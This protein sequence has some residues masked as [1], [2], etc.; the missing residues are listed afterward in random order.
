MLDSQLSMK[1]HI[2][3]ITATCFFQLRRLR[4]IRR[5]F[6]QEVTRRLVSACVTS[7]ND[8]SP[9]QSNAVYLWR[10]Y[11]TMRSELC[12]SSN[13]YFNHV[14]TT[15]LH[16]RPHPTSLVVDSLPYN[17]PYKF[18]LLQFVI[19]NQLC[20]RNTRLPQYVIDI[21]AV[22]EDPCRRDFPYPART[23]GKDN[24]FYG[25]GT[26]IR[27]Q[28]YG[29]GYTGFTRTVS[30]Y[31]YQSQKSRLIWRFSEASSKF[32]LWHS[33]IVRSVRTIIKPKLY[34]CIQYN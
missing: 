24:T 4:Q 32:Q 23:C 13:F 22:R 19:R 14:L 18:C 9:R 1:P 25:Y 6:G 28:S 34:I 5:R 17:I 33:L 15:R 31:Y 20:V 3:K 29:Y 30:W 21:W 7:H 26:G 12:C 27:I 11:S 2:A 8:Y 10:H 16:T